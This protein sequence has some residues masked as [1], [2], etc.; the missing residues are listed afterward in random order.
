MKQVN[1]ITKYYTLGVA[2]A[3]AAGPFLA[4]RIIDEGM[5]DTGALAATAMTLVA[6]LLAFFVQLRGAPSSAGRWMM[7]RSR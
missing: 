7:R 6:L 3:S 1:R 4:L 5:L 2:A